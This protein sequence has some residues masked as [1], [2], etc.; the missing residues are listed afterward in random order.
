[1]TDFFA[2]DALVRRVNNEPT[3]GLLAGRAL[4]L[5]LAHP[6]VGQGVEDHSDFKAQPL[7]RLQGTLE[8]VYSIV[9]GSAEL[10]EGMGRRIHWIH[11]FVVGPGYRANSADNLLWVHATLVDSALLAHRMFVG[12]LSAEEEETF[13]QQMTRVAE[14]L[15]L[16]AAAQPLTM[17]DFRRY[18]DRTVDTLEVTPTSR[19]LIRYVMRPALPARLDVPLGPLLSVERLITIGTTPPAIREQVGLS[20]NDDRQRRLDLCQG[21]I[22]TA[23]RLQ[24]RPVRTA[25]SRLGGQLLMYQ[26]RHHLADFQARHP[27]PGEVSRQPPAARFQAR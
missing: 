14:T 10:A 7:K 11:D 17:A 23:V 18:F 12:K 27:A 2:K 1:M 21:L 20:W 24:P 22:R 19:E 8:A 15:G 5:Q 26:A 4:V 13:Y 6:A 9:N 25:P 3:V 16:P